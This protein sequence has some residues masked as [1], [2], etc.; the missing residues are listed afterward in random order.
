MVTGNYF[1]NNYI[2]YSYNFMELRQKF[3]Y[4]QLIVPM[5][6]FGNEF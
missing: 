2:K 4:G 5:N 6:N 1:L 3:F